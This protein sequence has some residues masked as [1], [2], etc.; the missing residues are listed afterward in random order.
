MALDRGETGWRPTAPWGKGG[1]WRV[2]FWAGRELP[3]FH[4]SPLDLKVGAVTHLQTPHR[5]QPNCLPPLRRD[6]GSP[7]LNPP[8]TTAA[9]E[10]DS[11]PDHWNLSKG[12]CRRSVLNIKAK[13][14]HTISCNRSLFLF[15]YRC[16]SEEASFQHYQYDIWGRMHFKMIFCEVWLDLIPYQAAF[17]VLSLFQTSGGD[18]HTIRFQSYLFLPVRM[19]LSKQLQDLKHKVTD[20]VNHRKNKASETNRPSISNHVLEWD[21][22]GYTIDITF[23]LV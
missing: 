5:P 7:Q 3:Q 1:Y 2:A 15:T 6:T 23:S 14:E 22:D 21:T 17:H 20:W 11:N 19:L 13:E 16:G 10:S 8:V 18:H 12:A 4:I 9:C